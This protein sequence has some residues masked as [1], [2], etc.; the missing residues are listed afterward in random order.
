MDL[1]GLPLCDLAGLLLWDLTGLPLRDFSAGV[2]LLDLDF[3]L[4]PE[5]C[6]CDRDRPERSTDPPPLAPDWREAFD[7]ERERC[8]PAGDCDRDLPD[9][10][11]GEFGCDPAAEPDRAEPAGEFDRLR[12]CGVPERLRFSG[13]PDP[14][15]FAGELDR[16][17]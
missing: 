6:D 8:D 2:P 16:E 13:V 15:R 1:T 3:P 4:A 10:R 12:F 5:A 14:L 7:P 17:S 9:S 11:A